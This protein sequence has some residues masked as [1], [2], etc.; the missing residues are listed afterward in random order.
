M[1]WPP[2]KPHGWGLLTFYTQRMARRSKIRWVGLWMA[3]G[4]GV[5]KGEDLAWRWGILNRFRWLYG[6]YHDINYSQMPCSSNICIGICEFTWEH[7][8]IE[9]YQENVF[10][11]NT[12]IFRVF[13]RYY[14]IH[15]QNSEEKTRIQSIQHIPEIERY[16]PT[17]KQC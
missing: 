6:N 12:S 2:I 3:Q 15:V 9:A 10:W 1:W 13:M 11:V 16:P 4:P 8:P 5:L 14:C 7:R 17:P